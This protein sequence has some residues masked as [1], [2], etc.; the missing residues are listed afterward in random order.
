[1]KH[2]IN[3]SLKNLMFFAHQNLLIVIQILLNRMVSGTSSSKKSTNYWASSLHTMISSKMVKKIK[4]KGEAIQTLKVH[5]QNSENIMR[6]IMKV[7]QAVGAK[8]RIFTMVGD[9]LNTITTITNEKIR[10]TLYNIE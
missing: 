7:Q 10:E 2:Q 6:N 3:A 4:T 8:K 9:W 1:M 5:M